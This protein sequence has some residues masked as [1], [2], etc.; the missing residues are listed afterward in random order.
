MIVTKKTYDALLKRYESLAEV[1]KEVT[2]EKD[3]SIAM[4]E[5]KIRLLQEE[6]KEKEEEIKRKEEVFADENTVTLT[7]DDSLTTV[8]PR[9]VV[10]EDVFD[11]MVELH[12]LNDA[13]NSETKGMSMQLA[14][15]MIAHE[16]LDQII[17]AFSAA[18]DDG[19]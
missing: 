2:E 10:K 5:E 7:I 1:S 14:L 11:K 12:Y 3:S 4:L 9:V 13:V 18:V 19:E 15:M 6:L 16:S 17:E 8:I